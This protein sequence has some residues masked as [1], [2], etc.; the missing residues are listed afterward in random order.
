M[1]R[2]RAREKRT[3]EKK[4]SGRVEREERTE[5]TG[6]MEVCRG[7]KQKGEGGDEGE[8]EGRNNDE[9]IRC[10]KRYLVKSKEDK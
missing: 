7:R 10:G 8:E 6:G 1:R 9:K 4:E 2:G 3:G 5:K